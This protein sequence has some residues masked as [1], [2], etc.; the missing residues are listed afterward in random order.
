MPGLRPGRLLSGQLPFCIR[1]SGYTV[2][3]LDLSLPS[4]EE[5]LA[6]DELMLLEGE[7]GIAG[8]RLRCWELPTPVVVLGSASVLA[9]EVVEPA[10]AS[11]SVP[12]VRRFSGGGTVLL[13]RGCLAYSLVLSL[14]RPELADI[15]GSYRYILERICQTLGR[16]RPGLVSAGCSDLAVDGLKVGGS[17]QRRMRTHMLHHGTLLL[18]LDLTLLERYLRIP[19][20]QPVYRRGR[21]HA[22]FVANL[23]LPT[24]TV[25]EALVKAWPA[26]PAAPTM[27]SYSVDWNWVHRLVQEKYSRPEWTRRR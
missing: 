14:Q 9:E 20:R 18:D 8:E 26:V 13:G 16:L 27:S 5:N 19:R 22:E 2:E 25:K 10:C 24:E 1:H 23:A 7:A 15:A 3:Y 11:D 12:I 6:L 21:N 4:A 17:A